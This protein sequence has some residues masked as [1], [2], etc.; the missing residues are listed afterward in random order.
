MFFSTKNGE[1]VK[2][3]KF[4]HKDGIT[5]LIKKVYVLLPYFENS[6]NSMIIEILEIK[7]LSIRFKYWAICDI[8][9]KKT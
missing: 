7:N 5:M 1:I 2:S 8:K 4:V 3:M 6:I 9:K